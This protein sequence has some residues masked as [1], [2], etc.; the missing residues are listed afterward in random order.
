MG[1]WDTVK[2]WVK[3]VVS[4]AKKLF[5]TND[6]YTQAV[7]NDKT[8][9]EDKQTLN[10]QIQS[11]AINNTT[12]VNNQPMLTNWFNNLLSNIRQ[13]PATPDTTEQIDATTIQPNTPVQTDDAQ[14]ESFVSKLSNWF[15]NPNTK[16]NKFITSIARNRVIKDE[17]AAREERFAVGYNPDNKDV[18]YLD[19]NE[20]RWIWD[21]DWGTRKWTTEEFERQLAKFELDISSWENYAQ[22]WMDLYD[23]TKDLFR[24]DADDR[25]LNRPRR[26]ELYTEDEL[27][28]LAQSGKNEKWKYIPTI[29]EFQD[30][31]AMYMRNS[32]T[33]QELWIIAN[34][35]NPDIE[36]L[37]IESWK[38]SEWM[39]STLDLAMKNMDNYL[40]P[41]KDLNPDSARNFLMELRSEVLPNQLWRWY[42]HV[43][44]LYN[45]EEEIL[46]RDRSTWTSNDIATLEYAK[47]A[48]QLDKQYANNLNELARQILL[49]WTDANWDIVNTPTVFENWETLNDVLTKWFEE[50]TWEKH[51]Q[52]KSPIDLIQDLSNEAMFIYKDDKTKW[53]RRVWNAVEYWLTPVWEVLSEAWQTIPFVVWNILEWITLWQ[54]W[55]EVTANYLDQD[56]SIFRM[57]ETD[58]WNIKRTI[59]KYSLVF[60]E[61][62]PEVI[63]NTVPHVLLAPLTWW[64][65]IGTVVRHIKDVKTAVKV[66]KAAKWA[67]FLNKVRAVNRLAKWTKTLEEL[68][69]SAWKYAEIMN[70]A[71]NVTGKS[72]QVLKTA[73]QYLDRAIT[74]FSLWQFMDWQ[75]SEFDTEAYSD[76]SFLMSVVWS[77]IFDIFPNLARLTTGKALWVFWD[78][79]YNVARYIDSSSDAAKNIA[80]LMRKWTWELTVEDLKQFVWDFSAIENA[81]K[82]A[83]EQL[84]PDEKKAIWALTK[85]LTYSYIDQTFWANSTMWKRVRQIL[86]NENAN[87]ADVI[88]YMTRVPW[89][90]EVWPYVSTIRLKN[91]T[92]AHVLVEKG[93][94]YKPVLDSIVDWWFESKVKNWFSQWDLN[95]LSST[96]EY[97][98]I[99]RDKWK[100]FNAIETESWTKYYLNEKWLS[101]FW[102]KAE[103]LTLESLWVTLAEAENTREALNKLKWIDWINLSEST[104]DNI[105][106]TWW[107]NEITSKVKE[108]LWC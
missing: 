98:N 40:K 95:K 48:H 33:K 69:L 1:L 5:G 63:W 84:T 100:L 12:N 34:E 106:N 81:A 70:A 51:W 21:V 94:E 46:S 67:S 58:D 107:Y 105:S 71:K 89:L 61:Y 53:L 86:S 14:Q 52:H 3:R 36:E 80:N 88:K 2:S 17:Y 59:K 65:S 85:Q 68:W 62:T 30:F 42:A 93:T 15:T 6:T 24:L 19:L 77:W 7:S 73:A 108:V 54:L 45:A 11:G 92:Q 41:V 38:Q 22:A 16:V 44:Q 26:Y 39:W 102:L 66:A 28:S 10:Q 4:W 78:S 8:W 74:D 50:I 32:Q 101:H 43:A 31:V 96:T 87:I 83:Y 75:L 49:Y 55:G 37:T 29:E 97:S 35:Y 79:V 72:N 27:N 18:Y 64:W 90:V 99:E 104:I 9:D 13:Q 47:Q 20:D 25:H 57:L 91:W 103:S 23:N 82:Q 76:A 56:A 60:S